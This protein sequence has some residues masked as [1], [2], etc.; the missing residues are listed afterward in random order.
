MQFVLIRHGCTQGNLE[1]RYIGAWTDEA[2]LPQEVQRLKACSYPAVDAVFASPLRRCV[3]T[4]H[5]I[6]PTKAA[7]MVAELRE[8]DFG[9]FE[10]R[11]YVELKDEPAYQLWLDSCGEMPF[12]DGESRREF[13]ARCVRAF[14]E[15]IGA[16]PE[17]TYAFVVHGGTIMALMEHFAKPKGSYYDFQVKNGDGFILNLDGS[18]R[19][20]WG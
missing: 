17:G 13:S 19:C 8:C 14:E 10:N 18:Y 9:A 11:N 20:L 3:E 6:Y 16:L 4:A 1:G 2:L 15:R 12:P 7:H 5:L